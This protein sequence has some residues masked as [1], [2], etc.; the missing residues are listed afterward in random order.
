MRPKPLN[1]IVLKDEGKVG[2]GQPVSPLRTESHKRQA[3]HKSHKASLQSWVDKPSQHGKRH[4]EGDSSDSNTVTTSDT[5]GSSN[6]SHL[7][8]VDRDLTI[9]NYFKPD[10]PALPTITS[11]AHFTRNIPES[12]KSPSAEGRDRLI[13]HGQAAFRGN[14]FDSATVLFEASA[15]VEEALAARSNRHSHQSLL[16]GARSL[17]LFCS[18]ALNSRTAEETRLVARRVYETRLEL[19]GALHVDTIDSFRLLGLAYMKEKDWDSAVWCLG[20]VDLAARAVFGH[21]HEIV[22]TVCGALARLYT[23]LGQKSDAKR[24]YENAC[25]ACLQLGLED[26]LDEYLDDMYDLGMSETRF[27]I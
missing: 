22:A 9:V 12:L 1:F 4:Q 3:Q 27:G 6:V 20:Q 21:S 14:D 2:G 16:S 13:R 15:K 24:S 23:E 19:L 7:P 8:M 25:A 18:A 17:H 11:F 5:D 10:S 26:L